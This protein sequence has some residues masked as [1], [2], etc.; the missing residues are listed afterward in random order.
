MKK[1]LVVIK[2]NVEYKN[3][4]EYFYLI[5]LKKYQVYVTSPVE[6]DESF[7]RDIKLLSDDIIVIPLWQL[8]DLVF[9][10]KFKYWLK[11]EFFY[12]QNS[13][14]SE[15]CFQKFWLE[16]GIS[17]KTILSGKWRSAH[18]KII[19]LIFKITP[20]QLFKFV[21]GLQY[22]SKMK[23]ENSKLQFDYVLFM[24]PDSVINILFYNTFKTTKS[25]II[26]FVR[27]YDTP[28][29]KGVF[30]VKSDIS[31]VVSQGLKTLLCK[32]HNKRYVG[33]V[34]VLEKPSDKKNIKDK[35]EKKSI[36]YCTSHPHF[37]PQENEVLKNIIDNLPNNLSF[38]IRLHPVDTIDR[39][40]INEKFFSN[41]I[42]QYVTYKSVNGDVKF[43]SIETINN[44]K[45]ELKAFD[46]LI[47]HSSTVV[48]QAFDVG[49]NELYFIVDD[50][51]NYKYIF[52]REHIT[53]LIQ[54]LGIKKMAFSE[55]SHLF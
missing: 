27:N 16:L 49:I 52:K 25:K 37:F 7:V 14:I 33:H 46:V 38:K 48:K 42:N 55:F 35:Q 39:Y 34:K 8:D 43:H 6:R 53:L 3:F 54:E 47:T 50:H 19:K 9:F 21:D 15:S 22:V 30:T 51:D 44:F 36:L 28:A 20:N 5:N 24:R 40:A 29:L 13:F 41:P 4:V 23:G 32:L 10:D 2:D 26:T 11:K 45:N 12:L 17:P 18:K 1:L 31:V